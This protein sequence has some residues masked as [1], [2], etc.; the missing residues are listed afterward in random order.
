MNGRSSSMRITLR[1][2]SANAEMNDPGTTI[3]ATRVPHEHFVPT[4]TTAR[5]YSVYGYRI[6]GSIASADLE[7]NEA[8]Q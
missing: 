2:L 6:L 7:F 4:H 3:W 1:T 8:I 5:T